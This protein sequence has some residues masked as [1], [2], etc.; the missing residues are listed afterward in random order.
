MLANHGREFEAVEIRHAHI[1]ENECDF[2]PQQHLEA[3]V[4]EHAVRRFS[5][6]SSKTA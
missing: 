4:A 1:D 5:P 3:C 6:I 2:I